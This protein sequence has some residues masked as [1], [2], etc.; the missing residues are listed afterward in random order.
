[1]RTTLVPFACL[2]LFSSAAAAQELVSNGSFESGLSGWTL[3]NQVGSDGA[4]SLQSGAVSPVN[5]FP[6]PVPPAGVRAAMT[7]AQGPGSH[8]LYQDITIPSGITSA[9]L[10]FSMY[11]NNA[12]TSYFTPAHLDFAATST[13]GSQVLNQ[14]ARVDFLAATADPFSTGVSDVLFSV[15]QTGASTPPVT[16]YAALS[17]DVTAFLQARAGQTVRLRFAEVDNVNFFNFGV[18]SVSLTVPAPATLP[19]VG[20]GILARRRRRAG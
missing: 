10:S 11:L 17:T 7:D 9:S 20:L 14:Q 12:A 15:F 1:M 18:D 19:L 2:A 5:G 16:G 3:V 13:T 8:V 4:F 6:V